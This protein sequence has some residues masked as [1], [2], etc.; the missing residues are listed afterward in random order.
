[1]ELKI[2]TALL[3]AASGV[4]S[5]MGARAEANR[6]DANADSVLDKAEH[7]SIVLKRKY[8]DDTQQIAF[9]KSLAEYNKNQELTSFTQEVQILEDDFEAQ[10]ANGIV[11]MGYGGTFSS[12]IDAAEKK[13]NDKLM[14]IYSENS[15]KFL[16]SNMQID[17]YDRQ[18]LNLNE[19]GEAESKMVLHTGQV[20]SMQLQQQADSTRLAAKGA[21]LGTFAQAGMN[22]KL[23]S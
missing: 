18:I 14:A 23:M 21:L 8:Q 15:D 13:A 3:T 11:S 7:D 12:V 20:Q 4:T 6:L 17:E 19:V 16:Q 2:A 10:L 22:Y 9:Q 5:Y 1:M